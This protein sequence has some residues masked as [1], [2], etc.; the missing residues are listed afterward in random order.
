MLLLR[1]ACMRQV[2]CD[3]MSIRRRLDDKD[4]YTVH[5]EHAAV[6]DNK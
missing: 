3:E 1:K 5:A 2:F 6:Y 4:Q